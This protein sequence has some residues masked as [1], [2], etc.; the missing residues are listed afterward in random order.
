[1][2]NDVIFEH[3]MLDRTPT[4]ILD[5]HGL[6]ADRPAPSS[7]QTDDGPLDAYSQAVTAVVDRV[8]PAVVRVE[9][10][11]LG[12]AAGM[13]SGVVISPDGLVLTN[14]HVMQGAREA[15]LTLSDCDSTGLG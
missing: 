7:S 14:S 15:R 2:R 1:M 4:Y 5:R 6:A 13:G 10:G 11:V 9:P 12:W 3:A 8:A